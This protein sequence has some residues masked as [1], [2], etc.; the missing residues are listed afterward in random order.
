MFSPGSPEALTEFLHQGLSLPLLGYVGEELSVDTHT[1]TTQPLNKALK[2]AK[3]SRFL[4][5]IF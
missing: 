2:I 3:L 4:G 5:K 1:N